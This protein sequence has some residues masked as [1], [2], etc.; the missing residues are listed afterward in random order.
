MPRRTYITT[1]NHRRQILITTGEP[2][3]RWNDKTLILFD[4]FATRIYE[5]DVLS[6]VEFDLLKYDEDGEIRS[7]RHKGV[8]VDD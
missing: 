6:E 5:G 2:P 4:E 1:V 7:V 8:W 3:A